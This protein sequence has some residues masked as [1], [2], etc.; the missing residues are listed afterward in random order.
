MA[1]TK[2]HYRLKQGND[3]CNGASLTPTPAPLRAP[4]RALGQ[5]LPRLV[6][7]TM[8]QAS[9]SSIDQDGGKRRTVIEC[10]LS[11]PAAG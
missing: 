11:L 3:E 7:R 10:A 1:K 5:R 6:S 8:K 9:C 4:G 2:M